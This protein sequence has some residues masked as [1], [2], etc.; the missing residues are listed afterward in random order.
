MLY[1]ILDTI[2]GTMNTAGE[3]LSTMAQ[4]FV[5]KNRTK[6]KLN[7]LRMV[8]KSESELMN[9]AYIALGKD[10]YELDSNGVNSMMKFLAYGYPVDLTPEKISESYAK[11]LIGKSNSYKTI[12]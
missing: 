2:R 4:T 10:Y 5:E 8:M 1:N 7:R 11:Y 3:T 6:A 9:R 12:N